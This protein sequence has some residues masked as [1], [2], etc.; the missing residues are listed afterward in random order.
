MRCHFLLQGTFPTQGLNPRF[1][2]SLSLA[3]KT[4][5]YHWAT[6]EALCTKKKKKLFLRTSVGSNGRY[7]WLHTAGGLVWVWDLSCI[8]A[9]GGV[10]IVKLGAAGLRLGASWSL[11]QLSSLT[12]GLCSPQPGRRLRNHVTDLLSFQSWLS[13]NWV[14]FGRIMAHSC[15]RHKNEAE[16]WIYK[17]RFKKSKRW[18]LKILVEWLEAVYN[19]RFGRSLGKF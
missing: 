11:I 6:W 1:P 12:L 2:V 7:K 17:T 4:H 9:P 18:K 3:G 13:P 14:I 5:S 19:F 10:H 8:P 15:T 16:Y